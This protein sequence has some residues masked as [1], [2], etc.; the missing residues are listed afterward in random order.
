MKK[1]LFAMIL[2]FIMCFQPTLVLAA[3]N[4]NI[5]G[6]NQKLLLVMTEVSKTT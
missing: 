2:V 5:G 6:I 4:V 3:I 1:K